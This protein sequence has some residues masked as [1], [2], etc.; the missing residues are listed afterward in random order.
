VENN[1]T[2]AALLCG[3]VGVGVGGEKGKLKFKIWISF[4]KLSA[5]NLN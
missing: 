2:A 3:G 1:E 4:F 5:R